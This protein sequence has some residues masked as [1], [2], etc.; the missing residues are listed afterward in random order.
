LT[1]G[2]S[3]CRRNGEFLERYRHFAESLNSR[4]FEQFC[5]KF[6]RLQAGL[7]EALA[8]GAAERRRTA[9]TFNIFQVLDRTYDEVGTHSRV[10]ANLLD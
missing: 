10:L 8:Q 1:D 4:H 7:E 6:R 5:T 9:S 3:R 2:Y